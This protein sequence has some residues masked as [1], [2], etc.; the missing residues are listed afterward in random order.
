MVMGIWLYGI[1]KHV[2]SLANNKMKMIMIMLELRIVANTK[3]VS[4]PKNNTTRVL[5]LRRE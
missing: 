1:S 5:L 4:D 3:Y 2:Y